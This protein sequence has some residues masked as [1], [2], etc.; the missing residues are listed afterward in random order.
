MI[1]V[2]NG[3]HF[4]WNGDCVGVDFGCFVDPPSNV[5]ELTDSTFFAVGTC[6][7]WEVKPY[8]EQS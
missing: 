4:V 1:V 5:M 7:E 2:G 6:V 3:L 8:S